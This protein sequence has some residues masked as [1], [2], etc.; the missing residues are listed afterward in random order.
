MRATAR[1]GGD[2]SQWR[3]GT[4]ELNLFADVE[5]GSSE[6]GELVRAEDRTLDS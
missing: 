3:F 2:Y 1:P 6:H 5:A 4:L